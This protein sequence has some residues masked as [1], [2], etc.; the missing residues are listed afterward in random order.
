MAQDLEVTMPV[1]VD[2]MDNAVQTAYGSRPN[3]AYLIGTS[4]IIRLNQSWY[5]PDAMEIAINNLLGL[6]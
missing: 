1:L 6:N 2:G 5:N 3:N 4:G